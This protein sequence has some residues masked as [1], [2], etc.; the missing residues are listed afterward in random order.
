M[1][2]TRHHVMI[3]LYEGDQLLTYGR[4]RKLPQRIDDSDDEAVIAYAWTLLRGRADRARVIRENPRRPTLTVERASATKL[5][6][7]DAE[8]EDRIRQEMRIGA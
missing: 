5:P 2:K 4:P 1:P 7:T 3:G 6:E 8:R